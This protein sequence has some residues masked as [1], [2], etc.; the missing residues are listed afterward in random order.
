MLSGFTWI[1]RPML[2]FFPSLEMFTHFFKSLTEAAPLAGFAGRSGILVTLTGGGMGGIAR[3]GRGTI[4]GI[5]VPVSISA[6]G[7]A[8]THL[9]GSVLT[10]TTRP[11]LSS[12]V[13]SSKTSWTRQRD[14]IP[15]AK[16]G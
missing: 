3:V 6:S 5:G 11:S 15:W 2:G 12:G 1:I 14:H 8:R 16:W 7:R 10:L 4:A 9:V 13:P